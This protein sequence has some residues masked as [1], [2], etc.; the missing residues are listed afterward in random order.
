MHQVLG[1][2]CTAR[3]DMK[4]VACV[5]ALSYYQLKPPSN[6]I[7]HRIEELLSSSTY[8]HSFETVFSPNGVRVLWVLLYKGSPSTQPYQIFRPFEAPAVEDLIRQLL[9]SHEDSFGR[10]HIPLGSSKIPIPAILFA[11]CLLDH[12]LQSFRTTGRHDSKVKFKARNYIEFY[13]N[14]MR[15]IGGLNPVEKARFEQLRERIAL[16]RD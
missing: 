12:A 8:I 9:W 7:K 3:N 14:L 16:L 10:I 5:V 13:N 4:S 11:C 2:F 1:W 6:N 15:I